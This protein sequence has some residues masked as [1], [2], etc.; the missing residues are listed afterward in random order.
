MFITIDIFK[1]GQEKK[2]VINTDQISSIEPGDVEHNE[3]IGK[4]IC[5]IIMA[6]NDEYSVIGSLEEVKNR[7]VALVTKYEMKIRGNK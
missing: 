1:Y 3:D 6:N 4:D 5:Y 7:I 2:A